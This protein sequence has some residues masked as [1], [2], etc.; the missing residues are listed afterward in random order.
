M[1][2]W[3]H[4]QATSLLQVGVTTL[5]HPPS[6]K[7]QPSSARRRLRQ[8]RIIN[9]IFLALEPTKKIK[10]RTLISYWE[11]WKDWAD[12]DNQN[13]TSSTSPTLVA[14]NLGRLDAFT[15]DNGSVIQNVY[16]N[17]TWLGWKVLGGSI[18]SVVSAVVV[19]GTGS[20]EL[21]GLGPK[22]TYMHRS[23]S[24]GDNWPV[25]WDSHGGNYTSAPALVS[26]CDAIYDV[27]GI[28]N[29]HIQQ[30]RFNATNNSWS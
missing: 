16:E 15:V 19:K 6:M 7:N 28:E 29:K 17:K 25:A 12:V 13:Q 2:T 4:F 8:W 30:A 26:S 1:V 3:R 24:K 21:Y 9:W 23:N 5:R 22:S 11:G 27:F 14:T 18:S 10:H 20:I